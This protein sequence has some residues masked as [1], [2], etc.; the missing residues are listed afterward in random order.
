MKNFRYDGYKII[1]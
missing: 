1:K